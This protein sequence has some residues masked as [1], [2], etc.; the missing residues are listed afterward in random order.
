MGES[1]NWFAANETSWAGAN[2]WVV[3]ARDPSRRGGFRYALRKD[4]DARRFKTEKAAQAVAAKL[5]KD[6]DHG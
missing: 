6:K 4:H 1:L 3:K 5:N 2:Y